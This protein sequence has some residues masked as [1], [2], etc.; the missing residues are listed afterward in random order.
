MQR[1][2]GWP[3]PFSDCFDNS[4]HPPAALTEQVG[5]L[6]LLDAEVILG[7]E[8][9]VLGLRR[10]FERLEPPEHQVRQPLHVEHRDPPVERLAVLRPL[11]TVKDMVHAKCSLRAS[12][13]PCDTGQDS[14]RLLTSPINRV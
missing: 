14:A 5:D 1:S 7:P 8:L 12:S 11:P 13:G 4:S 10:Q 2:H 3:T 6:P 9:L